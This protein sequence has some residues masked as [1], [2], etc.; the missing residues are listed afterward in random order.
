MTFEK[1]F[2]KESPFIIAEVGNNHE[3]NFQTALK[4]IDEASKAG[5]DGIKFQTFKIQNF[6]NERFTNKKRFKILK[7]YHNFQ[8]MAKISKFS[9]ISLFP[10]RT[11][12]VGN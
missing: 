8:K 11:C 5:A 4:Y 6:Y 12:G 3:G 2:K 9:K 7:K 1:I 10:A